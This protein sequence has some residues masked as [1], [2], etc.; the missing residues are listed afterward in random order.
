MAPASVVSSAEPA[1]LIARYRAGH[2][3]LLAALDGLTPE[4]LDWR[5]DPE[6][7][8]VRDVV[9]HLEDAEMT[10][11]VRLRRLLTEDSP[12]LPAFD[13]EVYRRRLAYAARP[14]QPALDAIR[15]AHET[16]AELLDR[17]T[18]DDWRRA[19]THSEEGPY[20]LLR[21]LAFHATHTHDHAAQIR[22]LRLARVG[23]APPPRGPSSAR[24]AVPTTR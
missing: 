13:E 17:L 21:W 20:S 8:N 9:H 16:T 11:A 12:F 22:Q 19:G 1:D 14:I 2:G 7:W 5:P 4:A 24:G 18:A 15:A 3:V 6:A 10:G 23:A